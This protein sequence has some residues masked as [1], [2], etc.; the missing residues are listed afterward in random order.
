MSCIDISTLNPAE[1]KQLVADAQAREQAIK[2]EH[3][4]NTR[5]ELLEYAKAA[6]YDLYE[7][8]GI[9][10]RSKPG[11]VRATRGKSNLP[12]K[13]ADP[14]NPSVTWVGRGKRPAWVSDYVKGGGAI[15]DLLINKAA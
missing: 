10:T 6:G 14:R 13:Y 4:A 9:P 12:D 2:V 15:S 5:T 8:F 11:K 7:L 3:R 1:L